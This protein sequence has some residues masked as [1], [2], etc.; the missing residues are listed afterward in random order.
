MASSCSGTSSCRPADA[1]SAA[2]D[3]GGSSDVRAAA[4]SSRRYEPAGRLQDAST[5][6]KR[7]ESRYAMIHI[8]TTR[9]IL[10]IT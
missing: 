7:V 4:V 6:T 5:H 2:R 9:P 1:G 10:N 8:P 3:A